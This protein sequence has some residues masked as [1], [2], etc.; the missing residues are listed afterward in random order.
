MALGGYSGT[1]EEHHAV[2]ESGQSGVKG[3]IQI[4]E[5]GDGVKDAGPKRTDDPVPRLALCLLHEF[6]CIWEMK[7]CP[8]GARDLV[9]YYL[10]FLSR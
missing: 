10:S 6:G 2:G 3:C 8:L 4:W 1:Y 9:Q 7:W 5:V